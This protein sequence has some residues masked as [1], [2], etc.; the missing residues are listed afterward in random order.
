MHTLNILL[1][2][3]ECLC[4]RLKAC[5]QR[6]LESTQRD[7]RAQPG[8]GT[9]VWNLYN[10]WLFLVGRSTGSRVLLSV[11]HFPATSVEQIHQ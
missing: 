4:P 10:L 3:C 9:G 5:D 6:V 1:P 11:R 7:D 2:P 8:N